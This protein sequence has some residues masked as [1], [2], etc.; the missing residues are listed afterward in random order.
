MRYPRLRY[1]NKRGW[2][3]AS[4]A[5]LMCFYMP[6]PN[7][8]IAPAIIRA[9]EL[10]RERI[11][12]YRLAWNNTGDGQAEPLDD[13]SWERTRKKTLE[14]GPDR[15]G[16]LM[17]EGKGGVDDLHVDYRGLS[18]V[19]LPWPERKDDVCVL[20]LRLPTEY[21]EEWGPKH[22]RVLALELAAE[23]PFSSGYVDFVLCSSRADSVEALKL[24]RP[25]YQGVH[26]ASSG[27][28]MNVNTWVEG[29]HWMNFLGQPVL[30]KLGGMSGLRERLTLPGFSLQEMSGD[31]VLIT[32]GERPEVGDM[33][34][35]QTLP[36]H[37]ALARL[38]EPYLYQRKSMFG[39]PL[40][41]E[42]LR[43]DRRF[44]D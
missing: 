1:H 36:L 44:L 21:L 4:D 24:I 18:S 17:L 15:S 23:L 12:P 31:R 20:Y 30:G 8:R 16:T 5:L 39:R 7:E 2:L 38:L 26:L 19:P 10:F 40:P 29:I 33:E 27:A 32:L 11:R 41:E 14:A 34:V 42:L 9:V 6:H 3:G 25:R 43:W 28:T 37:R 13:A 22:V 35:G